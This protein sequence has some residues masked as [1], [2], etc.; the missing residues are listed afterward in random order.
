VGRRLRRRAG[1]ATAPDDAERHEAR[2]G[3]LQQALT[4]V[5]RR[6]RL[7]VLGRRARSFGSSPR[8]HGR[9]V[10]GVVTAYLLPGFE[11]ALPP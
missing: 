3:G 2:D 1:R 11:P 4:H 9:R 5:R 8:V 7:S 6:Y 10:T